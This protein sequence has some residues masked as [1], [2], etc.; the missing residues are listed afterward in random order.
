MQEIPNLSFAFAQMLHEYREKSG[1]SQRKLA[2]KIGCAR[3]YI[4]FLESGRHMP[5]LNTF[6]LL[7]NA[8]GVDSPEFHAEL[9][10][11]LSK[12]E[13]GEDGKS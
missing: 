1:L 3:S 7:A 5:T 9:K 8:F 12:M 10:I 2:M 13:E 4:A 6:M 11:R